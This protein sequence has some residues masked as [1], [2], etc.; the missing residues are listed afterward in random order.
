M[1]LINESTATTLTKFKAQ[2]FQWNDVM[3]LNLNSTVS[4][5][6]KLTTKARKWTL[7]TKSP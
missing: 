7:P 3:K 2:M 5:N 4:R 6:L 1:D